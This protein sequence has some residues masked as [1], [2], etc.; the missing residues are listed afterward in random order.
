MTTASAAQKPLVIR[1]VEEQGIKKLGFEDGYLTVAA[2][3]EL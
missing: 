3:L 1:A 2:F